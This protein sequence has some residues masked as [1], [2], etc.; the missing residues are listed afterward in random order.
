[1]LNE[2]T[3]II[4]ADTVEGAMEFYEKYKIGV[5]VTDGKYVHFEKDDE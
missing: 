1:M 4:E 5:V 3:L 2:K